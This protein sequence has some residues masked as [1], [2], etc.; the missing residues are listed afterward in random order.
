MGGK[1]DLNLTLN[2][3]T[4][5]IFL[6]KKMYEYNVSRIYYTLDKALICRGQ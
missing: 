4:P 5:L 6:D 1:F 3:T 2:E